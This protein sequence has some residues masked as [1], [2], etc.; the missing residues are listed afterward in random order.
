MVQLEQPD[1]DRPS[2]TLELFTE[3]AEVLEMIEN[4]RNTHNSNF[5]KAYEKFSEIVGR[6][7][8]QSHLLDPHLDKLILN[9]LIPIRN[10]ES[11]T[12]LS[13]AAFKYLYQLSKVRTFKAMV[14]FLPHEIIDFDFVLSYVERQDHNNAEH[15]ETRYVLLLWLS[16]LILNPFEMSRLDIVSNALQT[17]NPNQNTTTIME[18]MFTLCQKNTNKNDTCAQVASFLTS[19]YLIRIDIKD[20]F[21]PRFFDWIIEPNQVDTTNI[22]FGQLAA[23]SAILKHGKREDLLTH[24][25]RLLTWIVGCNYKDSS[26]YLK[27]KYFMKI[28]QRLGNFNFVLRK[29]FNIKKIIFLIRID[30]TKTSSCYL[31]IST[32]LTIVDG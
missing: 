30:F 22:K 8:E 31:E 1:D 2:N 16:M 15:W 24:A 12:S 27:S 14:K 25:N 3:H 4:L 13:N 20:K 23:I 19:R 9:L 17:N 18:R 5:E 7:Q 6:Y 28:I 32:W 11:S 10:A 29:I 21:L 26:D